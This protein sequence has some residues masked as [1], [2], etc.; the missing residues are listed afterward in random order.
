MKFTWLLF[1]ILL[2]TFCKKKTPDPVNEP[3]PAA[4]VPTGDSSSYDALFASMKSYSKL[5][6]IYSAASG[7]SFAYYSNQL[8]VKET[9]S[10]GSLQNIGTVSLNGTILKSKSLVG[11]FYYNDTTYTNFALPHRWKIL[12][13]AAIDSFSFSN[14]NPYPT[15]DAALLL[16][17]SMNLGSGLKFTMKKIS[18]CSLIKVSLFG[19]QGSAVAPNKLIAGSDS[20]LSFSADELAGLKPTTTA[21][22]T[23]Q[24]FNDNYRN[25]NGKRVNFR[26][27]L[28]Y[29]NA[30]FKIKP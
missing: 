2:L 28:S 6:G 23:V 21:Y 17:D 15:F 4:Q 9:Y 20:V 5:S 18:N 12:G 29:T 25:I 22:L 19:G 10:A 8:I 1:P 26:T 14:P 16:P 11:E 3:T 7:L 13:S 27:G 24:L 30:Y